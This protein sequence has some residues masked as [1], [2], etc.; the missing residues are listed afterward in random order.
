MKRRIR[1]ISITAT[2]I[3]VLLVCY[4]LFFSSGNEMLKEIWLSFASGNSTE[5][6]EDNIGEQSEDEITDDSEKEEETN[7]ENDY[8][9]EPNDENG[10]DVNPIDLIYVDQQLIIG[11]GNFFNRIKSYRFRIQFLFNKTNGTDI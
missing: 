4:G 3:I 5:E 6:P 9:E 2:V 1:V 10:Q 8:V 7:D 11:Y